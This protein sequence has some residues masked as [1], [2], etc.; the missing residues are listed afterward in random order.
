MARSSRRRR[1]PTKITDQSGAVVG[2]QK[3]LRLLAWA[4]DDYVVA[5]GCAGECENEFNSGLVLVSVDGSRMTQLTANHD[6]NNGEW[7]WVL[8]PRN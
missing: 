5:V 4:D 8:T 7:S 2:K 3:V 1:L 6:R